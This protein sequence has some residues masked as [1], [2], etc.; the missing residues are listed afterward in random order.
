M[1]YNYNKI[2]TCEI[3][4]RKALLFHPGARI[5]AI[6]LQTKYTIFLERNDLQDRAAEK[7]NFWALF[8]QVVPRDVL[9]YLNKRTFRALYQVRI[10]LKEHGLTPEQ[11]KR[12]EQ[13][14]YR[15]GEMAGESRLNK[16]IELNR[17]FD[18]ADE[19]FSSRSLLDEAIRERDERDVEIV[20]AEKSLRPEKT[21]T[22]S[23]VQ[24]ENS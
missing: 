1:T 21:E 16:Q 8:K 12:L 17:D 22:I 24:I 20:L 6:D 4:V 15:F 7:H 13:S 19:A 2:Q 18:S 9:E 11:L 3:S 14:D 23:L 5:K 10:D